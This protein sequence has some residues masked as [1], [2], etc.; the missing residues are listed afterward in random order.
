MPASIAGSRGPPSELTLPLPRLAYPQCDGAIR[1]TLRSDDRHRGHT[2]PPDTASPQT[3]ALSSSGPTAAQP[4]RAS[5]RGAPASRRRP[6]AA[7]APA[8]RRGPRRRRDTQHPLGG[9]QDGGPPRPSRPLTAGFH[10]QLRSASLTRRAHRSRVDRM[11]ARSRPEVSPS[12]HQAA[13]TMGI[14]QVLSPKDPDPNRRVGATSSAAST[15]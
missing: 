10:R 2:R 6:I 4:T 14:A 13:Q 15:A 9:A 7:S 11:A 5:V 1:I 3:A 12:V 8:R